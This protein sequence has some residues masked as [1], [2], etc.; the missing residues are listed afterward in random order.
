MCHNNNF[1][2]QEKGISLIIVFFIL[3]IMLAIVLSIGVLLYSQVK[4]IR[5]IGN[6]VVAFYAADSGVEKVL[7]YDRKQIPTDGARG[8][9]NIGNVCSSCIPG[10]NGG[11]GDCVESNCYAFLPSGTDCGLTT[12]TNCTVSFASYF[13]DKIYNISASAGKSGTFIT[14]T[15]IDS[16][17]DY[18]E[19]SRKVHLNA[20]K[21]TCSGTT[22]ANGNCWYKGNAGESCT[23]VCAR[24]GKTTVPSSRCVQEDTGCAILQTFFTCS[25]C[26]ADE[27]IPYYYFGSCNAGGVSSIE[28]WCSWS[29][30]DYSR[31]CVCQ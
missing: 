7:Y 20:T 12:C 28:D 4:V 1:K 10:T 8:L 18:K 25:F 23:D 13:E 30:P 14:T 19:V 9:C 16:G 15:S 11:P 3:T 6:S 26:Y 2:I 29:D 21:N 17:G 5:N 27:V 24:N 31:I 22:D